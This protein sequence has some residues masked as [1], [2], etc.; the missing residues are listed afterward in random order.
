M[1]CAASVA[2][3]NDACESLTCPSLNCDMAIQHHE[4]RIIAF[5]MFGVEF[6]CSTGQN[7]SILHTCQRDNTPR[8]SCT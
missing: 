7:E 5:V 1:P 4:R 3:F 6:D 8:Q 2:D